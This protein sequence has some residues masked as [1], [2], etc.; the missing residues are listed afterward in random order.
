MSYQLF[1][2]N[3]SHYDVSQ[4]YFCISNTPTVRL[5]STVH[6]GEVAVEKKNKRSLSIGAPAKHVESRYAMVWFCLSSQEWCST[7]QEPPG[8]SYTRITER[9]WRRQRW[10]TVFS[11]WLL[12]Y[13]SRTN[14]SRQHFPESIDKEGKP[15]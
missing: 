12:Q 6:A 7:R 11:L 15:I 5:R 9:R 13:I 3:T 14:G 8:S 1:Y 4:R 10:K 2:E